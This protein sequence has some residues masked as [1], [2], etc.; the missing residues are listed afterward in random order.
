M[1]KV[2]RQVASLFNNEEQ[3]KVI[4]VITDL[5]EKHGVLDTKQPTALLD[6]I[7]HFFDN[8]GKDESSTCRV[9]KMFHQKFVLT[10]FSCVK[11]NSSTVNPTLIVLFQDSRTWSI[12]QKL[13]VQGCLVKLH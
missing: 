13:L 6:L 9:F 8:L 4:S 3:E 7:A 10:V 2:A 11:A 5:K 12:G 1:Y